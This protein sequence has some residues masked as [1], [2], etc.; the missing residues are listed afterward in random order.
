MKISMI[1][2]K[3]RAPYEEV[4]VKDYETVNDAYTGF[5]S[6]FPFYNTE[7]LHQSLNYQTP[8]EVYFKTKTKT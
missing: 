2:E 3:N 5:T 6:Y 8:N 7:R 1:L 4:Y